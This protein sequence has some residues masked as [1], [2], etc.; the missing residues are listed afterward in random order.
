MRCD[1][2]RCRCRRLSS[3]LYWCSVGCWG[4][5][6][7]CD[8]PPN[9]SGPL[10]QEDDKQLPCRRLVCSCLNLFPTCLRLKKSWTLYV[11]FSLKNDTFLLIV[12]CVH[13]MPQSCV[14]LTENVR[15]PCRD[16]THTLRH[17][18][19]AFEEFRSGWR[20]ICQAFQDVNLLGVRHVVCPRRCVAAADEA[21][22]AGNTSKYF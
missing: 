19:H 9:P 15:R 21:R 20:G 13:H 7:H 10:L 2:G 16:R 11:F 14:Q 4:A 5:V 12:P 18:K 1:Y 17:M 6:R 3:R 22:T 8:I